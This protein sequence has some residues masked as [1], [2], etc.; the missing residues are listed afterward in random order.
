MQVAERLEVT[1]RASGGDTSERATRIVLGVRREAEGEPP[2]TQLLSEMAAT[3]QRRAFAE[4]WG[5]FHDS[6]YRFETVP[7]KE[8]VTNGPTL[9]ELHAEA[10]EC[11]AR[12]DAA[13]ATLEERK[14]AGK[15]QL[16]LYQTLGAVRH[17]H[18]VGGLALI[19][20]ATRSIAPPSLPDDGA[21]EA[22]C[23]EWL[24]SRLGP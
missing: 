23:A 5:T 7:P 10:L 22:G 11:K 16:K 24:V 6:L 19:R 1:M 4:L 15:L 12:I 9:V 13:L 21:D 18:T 8:E 20:G 14:A 2:T 3:H 17:L